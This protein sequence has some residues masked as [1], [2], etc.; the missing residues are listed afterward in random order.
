MLLL[1]Q[2]EIDPYVKNA[3]KFS[4]WYIAI[5]ILLI[6]SYRKLKHSDISWGM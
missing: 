4:L 2:F 5:N 6:N 3:N 1:S